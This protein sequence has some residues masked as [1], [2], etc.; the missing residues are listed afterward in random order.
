MSGAIVV[1]FSCRKIDKRRVACDTIF[2]FEFFRFILNIGRAGRPVCCPDWP[3]RGNGMEIKFEHIDD[4]AAIHGYNPIRHDGG[5]RIICQCCGRWGKV[6]LAVS[7]KKFTQVTGWRHHHRPVMV[8]TENIT[9][10][11][12]PVCSKKIILRSNHEH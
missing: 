2:R 1:S 9:G 4:P 3:I 10:W 6:G 5:L 8:G 7:L 11:I 12:C